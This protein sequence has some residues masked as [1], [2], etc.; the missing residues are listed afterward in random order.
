MIAA[1]CGPIPGIRGRIP[2]SEVDETARIW[3]IVESAHSELLDVVKELFG[4]VNEDRRLWSQLDEFRAERARLHAEL[5]REVA[6]G[7]GV[8]GGGEDA[9]DDEI[10]SGVPATFIQH[11]R[12][13]VH[14]RQ[15]AKASLEKP[16]EDIRR[17]NDVIASLRA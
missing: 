9:A 10:D 3:A 1:G 15:V 7:I 8:Q 5:E 2:D 17:A 16:L 14:M 6:R 11:R 13:A 12:M 4:M